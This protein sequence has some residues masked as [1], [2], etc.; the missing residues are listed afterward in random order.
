MAPPRRI[1]QKRCELCGATF[2]RP[3]KWSGVMF[4]TKRFC[5]QA[6]AAQVIHRTNG[7]ARFEAYQIPEPNSGCFIWLG[8]ITQYGYG[9]FRVNGVVWLAH[10]FAYKM[11]HGSLP[12]DLS[13]LHHCDVRPCV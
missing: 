13:V 10:R 11:R 6:C 12:A 1:D 7:V 4:Q 2:T 8:T 9:Q 5:S 3:P